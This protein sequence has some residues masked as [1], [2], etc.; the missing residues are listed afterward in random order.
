MDDR[1]RVSMAI[2]RALVAGDLPAA[3]KGLGNPS[4]W[5]DVVDPYLGVSVL[6]RA[7]ACAPMAAIHELLELGANPNFHPLD[8]GFPVLID[9]IHHWREDRSARRRSDRHDALVELL[10]A[11]ADVHARGL[12]DWTAL[13]CA[14]VH[15]DGEAVGLLLAAGADPLART[16]IDDLESV[17]ELAERHGGAADQVLK[18]WLAER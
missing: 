15:D 17:I 14:C 5:P 11:G 3:R 7:L 18:A 13:H 10:A 8:D 16:R 1:M 4:G 9:V 2:E 12:N 6:S